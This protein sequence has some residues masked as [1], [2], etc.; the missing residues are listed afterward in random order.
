MTAFPNFF[1]HYATNLLGIPA[2]TENPHHRALLET[3]AEVQHLERR[4]LR[5]MATPHAHGPD[6]EHACT[7]L[8]IDRLAAGQELAAL[9]SVAC[10]CAA[11]EDPTCG[12]DPDNCSPDCYEAVEDTGDEDAAAWRGC[13]RQ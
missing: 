9:L 2:E 8:L 5:A 4:L 12:D 13:R 7:E 6:E 3:Y 11:E 10:C 1:D